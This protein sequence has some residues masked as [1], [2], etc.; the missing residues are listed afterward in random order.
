MKKIITLLVLT[1][2]VSI[3]YAQYTPMTAAGYQF[4]RILCDSTLHIPSFCGIPTL[5]NSSAKNGAI[6]MDTCNNK[7]YKWT[8]AAGWSE[9]SGTSIDTTNRFVNNVISV[10]D[11]TIRVFKGSTNTTITLRPTLPTYTPTIVPYANASGVLTGAT[12]D[13]IYSGNTL[14][15]GSGSAIGTQHALALNGGRATI[16]GSFN[17]MRLNV[18]SG[19]TGLVDASKSFSF[20]NKGTRYAYID[21]DGSGA[22]GQDAPFTHKFIYDSADIYIPRLAGVSDSMAIFEAT[23]GKLKAAAIPSSGTTPNLQQVTD[24]SPVGTTTNTLIVDDGVSQITKLG[25]TDYFSNI[26][27]PL[28]YSN[29]FQGSLDF[30]DSLNTYPPTIFGYNNTSTN[31]SYKIGFN[32]ATSKPNFQMI[33]VNSQLQLNSD[34]LRFSSNGSDGTKLEPIP[35]GNTDI[36]YLPPNNGVNDTLV[37]QSPNDGQYYAYKDGNWAPFTPGGGAT[38]TGYY[39]AFQDNTTQTAVSANTAYPVKFNTTDLTNGVTVVNDGSSNPTRVTLANTGI[40]NIQFSLQLEKTGGSGNM[41]ADIWVRKNGIDIPSTTGKVVLTGSANASPIVAAWNYVLDLAAGDYVQLMWATSNVN[42]EIVA[43]GATSPHPAI[44]SSILTVTQQS[45]IMAGTGITAINSLT[46]A[47]Q[48]MVTG[49]DSTDFKIVS[50]GTSHTFNLPT[51]SATNRGA[52][53]SSN[54]TTFNNKIGASDTSVFQRKSISANTIMANNTASAANVAAQAF[55]DV[56]EQNMTNTIT[57]TGTAPTTLTSANYTWQQIGKTVNMQFNA[58][59]ANAGASNTGYF[60]TLPSD[61]PAPAVPTGW[62]GA[63]GY[64]YTGSA[65]THNTAAT[66]NSNVAISYIRRNSAN[67]AFEVGFIGTGV[68]AR[69]FKINITYKAQ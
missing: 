28:K 55:Y 30:I 67:T 58:L 49:T 19:T 2:I 63:S 35:N 32:S 57:W 44:P 61:M 26:V 15:L 34:F 52:L 21:T 46:G 60:F 47:A 50:T 18:G 36:H 11:S 59:Y 8:R 65:S 25:F 33:G 51:A 4:K 66:I 22:L 3:S 42:V 64:L 54:W 62:T 10:N 41:I 5:R 43:A 38:P 7:L 14:T 45:G 17:G 12:S 1:F 53:S 69:G 16:L 56:A 6:A 48:T 40:Y 29:S 23:T 39:G 20:Y 68:S 24:V 31:P 9:I 37:S 27:Y 13:M